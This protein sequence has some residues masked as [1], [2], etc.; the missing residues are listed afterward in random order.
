MF[1]CWGGE[2][3][4]ESEW[5]LWIGMQQVLRGPILLESAVF[6]CSTII[7]SATVQITH[8]YIS[9]LSRGMILREH[10]AKVPPTD[11]PTNANALT[12]PLHRRW[13]NSH[14]DR[15][16]FWIMI[17]WIWIRRAPK[18]D[19]VGISK[20]IRVI[21]PRSHCSSKAKLVTRDMLLYVVVNES[22]KFSLS[23]YIILYI[24]IYHFY[25][26]IYRT[27]NLT[28]VNVFSP[29]WQVFK[30]FQIIRYSTTKSFTIM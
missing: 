4:P 27:T 14:C 16:L 23:L 26:Y 11:E 6:G 30:C 15:G 12:S 29:K 19:S 20:V 13:S 1:C 5:G 25:V 10:F 17:Q 22:I 24:Y 21:P 18:E 9:F 28:H 7:S 2:E 8:F 3:V